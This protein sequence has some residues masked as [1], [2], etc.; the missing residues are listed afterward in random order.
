[1]NEHPLI[2]T[3]RSLFT[4][5]LTCA[6]YQLFTISVPNIILLFAA[7]T[8]VH[9][10]PR[11]FRQ[12][13]FIHHLAVMTIFII[14]YVNYG[15]DLTVLYALQSE[16]YSALNFLRHTTPRFYHYWRIGTIIFVRFP[17]W[18]WLYQQ[19]VFSSDMI[20]RNVGIGFWLT[21]DTRLLRLLII[22][23]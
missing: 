1:M 14:S 18:I 22:K 11:L 7:D 23:K 6:G 5:F 21:Y 13:L 16:I 17:L 20:C 10:H 19:P 15:D 4:L 8:A 12:D 9:C 3:Y 2:L